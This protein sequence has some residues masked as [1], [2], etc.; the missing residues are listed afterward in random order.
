MNEVTFPLHFPS[1][2]CVRGA[3]RTN[4]P[5]IHVGRTHV[6]GKCMII[7]ICETYSGKLEVSEMESGRMVVREMDSERI[8]LCE[9][10]NNRTYN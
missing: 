3:T 4:L 6:L 9:L 1:S 7:E 10:E 8:E 2:A 5:F